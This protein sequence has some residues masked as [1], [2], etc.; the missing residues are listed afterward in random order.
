M[1]PARSDPRY[2]AVMHILIAGFQ[3][4]T[5]T[6]ADSVADW[7]AFNQGATF[8]AAARGDDLR[9]KL[10]GVN[11]PAA[12]FLDAAESAGHVCTL[13]FWAGATPSGYVCRE[14]FERICQEILDDVASHL[15]ADAVYLDLHGAAVAQH[16]S[17][18]EGE[19][20]QRVRLLVGDTKPIVVSLDLHANVSDRMLAL[21]DAVVSYRKYPHTDMADTGALAFELL[22]RRLK[23]GR[24]EP[25]ALIRLP[26][27]I[28]LSCQSTWQQPAQGVYET[29]LAQDRLQGTTTSFCPGFPAAD[30][31]ACAPCCWSYG[32]QAERAI[33]AMKAVLEPPG[34]WQLDCLSSDDAVARAIS[35]AQQSS[36]PVLIADIQDN[37]GAGGDGCTTGL[38]HALLRAKAG[39][40]LKGGVA[41]GLMHDPLSAQLAHEAGVGATVS[42]ALGKS[43]R[44]FD[45]NP[46]DAPVHAQFRVLALSDGKTT[47]TGPMVSRA[48][49]DL[50][51]SVALEVD[52]IR[53]AVASQRKQ[54]LD[55]GLFQMVGIEPSDC[56]LLVV[57]SSNHYRAHFTPLVE[58]P[59]TDILNAK[60]HGAFAADPADLNWRN[61][62]KHLRATP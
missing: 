60:A 9:T 32:E 61:L 10:R 41:L 25:M 17:D 5:N 16:L 50:G 8:L 26:H 33:D 57:K 51:P 18:C 52:G 40:K 30:I 14:A 36:K 2:D 3:H 13:G 24:R 37:P 1:I 46:T 44:G 49:V 48:Q 11:L 27:L 38:L 7:Q 42:L 43:V 58:N 20:L 6:F 47:L 34:Q 54:M 56:K 12:G 28:P 15:T 22:K 21:A 62:P 29:L 53:V 35:R 39:L 4:E 45:G 59:A 55:Q 23:L 19:L 31:E